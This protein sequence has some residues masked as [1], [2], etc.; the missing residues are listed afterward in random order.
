[1]SNLSITKV[2]LNCESLSGVETVHIFPSLPSTNQT[3]WELID[4]GAP[5]GTAVIAAEQ[6]AG[7]GQWGRQWLSSAGGLYLSWAIAPDLPVADSAQL[8]LCSAWGIAQAL[9][10]QG[11]PVW[12]KWPNDLILTERKLAGILTETRVQK[13]RIVQAVI[14]A[15]INWANPVPETGINLQTF[16]AS[17][18]TPRIAS[19]E[20]LAAIALKGLTAGYRQ[21][22]Q[23]GIEFLLPS[24]LELLSGVGHQVSIDGCK[25]TIIGVTATG[26]LRVQIPSAPTDTISNSEINLKP[27]TISLGYG[28]KNHEGSKGS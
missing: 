17:E 28:N 5:P 18:P 26:E 4:Q 27:G 14:G 20:T 3:L 19:L 22:Q 24:Y 16:L 8:T 2:K 12:L 9:R 7:R 23:G 6:T 21:L 1:M 10:E 25:G 11:I 13:G 15:G